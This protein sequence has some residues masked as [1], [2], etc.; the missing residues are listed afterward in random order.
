MLK[1]FLTLGCL[2]ALITIP[3]YL[4]AFKDYKVFDWH[5][6]PTVLD[7]VARKTTATPVE[8]RVRPPAAGC[9]AGKL[10]VYP[11]IAP[12]G[13]LDLFFEALRQAELRTPGAQVRVLHY[14]DS[15]TTADLIT[16][17]VRQL[18][19]SSLATVAMAIT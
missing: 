4:P 9:K 16:A 13:S 12:P 15:P 3:D 19:P 1:T 5:T 10:G 14:G 2:T 6:V 8:G 7:F 11:I 17:D 18:L